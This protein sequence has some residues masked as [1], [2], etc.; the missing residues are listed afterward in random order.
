MSMFIGQS[1]TLT[2]A[3]LATLFSLGPLPYLGIYSIS[4]YRA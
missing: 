1:L 3:N 4:T 2:I